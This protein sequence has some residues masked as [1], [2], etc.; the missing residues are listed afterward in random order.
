[1]VDGSDPVQIKFD[2]KEVDCPR[3]SQAVHISPHNSGTVTNSEESSIKAKR[4]S[5]M[6]FPTSYQPSRASPLT[7]QGVVQITKFDVFRI[8]FDNRY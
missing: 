3:K 2:G 6:G 4:K 1:M 5:T 7:S 8:N